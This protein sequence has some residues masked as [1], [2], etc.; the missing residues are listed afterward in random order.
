ML[1][2]DMKYTS[3][4]TQ[5]S[6]VFSTVRLVHRP[7]LVP[8]FSSIVSIANAIVV[9]DKVVLVQTTTDDFLV[10]FF[11]DLIVEVLGFLYLIR[12]EARLSRFAEL[13][14]LGEGCSSARHFECCCGCT[15]ASN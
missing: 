3:L 4:A 15:K 5:R 14:Q 7:F 6:G 13:T 12:G 10:A 11:V 9:D 8:F 1:G 2:L